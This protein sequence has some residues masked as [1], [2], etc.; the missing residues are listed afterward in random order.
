M[1]LAQDRVQWRTLLLAVLNLRVLVPESQ[2][3][4]LQG[5]VHIFVCNAQCRRVIMAIGHSHFTADS[6]SVSMSWCQA[7]FVDI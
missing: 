2:S 6:H 5:V 7:H 1:E 3:I 4:N